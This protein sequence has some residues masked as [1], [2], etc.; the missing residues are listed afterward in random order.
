MRRLTIMF[1]LLGSMWAPG[2][3]QQTTGGFLFTYRPHSGDRS[4]FEDGYR[5]HLGWHERNRDTLPWFAWDVLVGRR[6]GVFVDGTFGTSFAAMDTRVDP[7][8]DARDAAATFIPHAEATGRELLSLRRELST[9]TPLED[10]EPTP[11]VQVVRYRTGPTGAARVE[12]ALAWMRDVATDRG[13][14]PY[15]VYESLAGHDAGF[16]VM[17]WRVNLASFDLADTNPE[18]V[19]R[20]RIGGVAKASGAPAGHPSIRVT[21]ELWRYRP[22]LAYFGPQE[23]R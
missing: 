5:R 7:A 9:A 12:S 18:R 23:H 17:I 2:L 13:L 15:T 21:G 4:A 10:L 22:D 16:L 8:G 11:F 6:P 1:L 20:R 14:Q 3:A 19:L